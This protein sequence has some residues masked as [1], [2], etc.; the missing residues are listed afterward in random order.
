MSIEG[1]IEQYQWTSESEIRND[2]TSRY[3]PMQPFILKA[4]VRRL[5]DVLFVDVGANIGFYAVIIGSEPT[6]AEVHA[7]EPMPVGAAATRKNTAANLPR[8]Q[9][10]VHQLALS[11]EQGRLDFAVRGP[12]AGANGAL[13][14]SV[15]DSTDFVVESVPCDQLDQVLS[16]SGRPLVIKV[17]VEGHELSV[18][19]GA[20]NILRDNPGFLQMEMHESPKD[21]EKLALLNRLGWHLLTRV[22]PDHYFSNISEYYESRSVVADVLEEA[23]SICL[24]SSQSPLRASRRRIASGVYLQ[25]SRTKVDRVKIALRGLGLR[26][27]KPNGA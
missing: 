26:S 3:E 10:V 17:D 15:L 13:R 20:V 12:L 22:G 4:L 11:D 1:L 25:V 8:Q 14:D 2:M 6:V 21:A 27:R 16:V 24:E 18:L 19:L 23:L 5:S 7:F 9:V